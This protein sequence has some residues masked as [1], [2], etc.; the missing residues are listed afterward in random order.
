MG[1]SVRRRDLRSLVLTDS[2]LDY[3]VHLHLLRPGHK[4]GQQAL[5]LRQFL[6][7]L[8]SRY[9]LCI[10][11]SPPGL[12][13]SNELLQRNRQVLERR[14]RDLGLLIGVNDAEV[15]KRLQPRYRLTEEHNHDLE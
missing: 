7:T 10:E 5:S 1:G 13:I 6:R 8:R 3:L 9:G 14:L 2:A 12:T 4:G 15:M 11:E